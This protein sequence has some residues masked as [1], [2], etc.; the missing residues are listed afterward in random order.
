MKKIAVLGSTGMAGH[1]ISLYLDSKGYEITL[2]GRK[3]HPY[4]NTILL[5]V[6]D[7]NK[8]L[9]EIVI[10]EFDVVINC[11]GIL[12]KASEENKDEAILINSYLPQFLS[13]RL[14]DTNVKLIQLSTDCVFS[15]KNG[16]YYED[17][18]QNGESFYDR[19]KILGEINNNKDL[20]FRNS[21]IGPEINPNGVGLFNWF[22]LQKQSVF[23]YK[24]VYWNGVTTLTLAKA[25]HASIVQ[26]LRGVYHLVGEK[27]SKHN[28]LL[29]INETFGKNLNIIPDYKIKSNKLLINTR[30]DFDFVV[31]SYSKMIEE[32]KVWIDKYPDLYM[33][34]KY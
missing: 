27:I 17:S 13:K 14:F 1:I 20:T 18:I 3:K 5:D 15:G 32:L 16:P 19:T 22:M 10:N 6:L 11:V 12:I 33:H 29:I 34:Y 24:D 25:I 2:I 8:L 28:L 31:P 4:I 21:I 26:D 23:G 7:F 30:I 9:E